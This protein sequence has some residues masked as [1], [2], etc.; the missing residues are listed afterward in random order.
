MGGILFCIDYLL[1]TTNKKDFF[2]MAYN[3]LKGRVKLSDSDSASIEGMVN[4]KDEQTIEG[5]KTFSSIVVA[6]SG[7]SAS[8]FEG[9]GS[10]LTNLDVAVTSYEADKV[11]SILVCSGDSSVSGAVGLSYGEEGL[12][13]Q[14]TIHGSASGLTNI[15][16][17]QFEGKIQANNLSLGDGLKNNGGILE[18]GIV[19][20][21]A[22]E[23]TD[24]G[25]KINPSKTVLKRSPSNNDCFIISDSDSSNETK[26]LTFQSLTTA[27]VNSITTYPPAGN[28]GEIQIKNGSAF[29]GSSELK[30][31]VNS[32][33]LTTKVVNAQTLSGELQSSQ[34]VGTLN[35]SQINHDSSIEADGDKLSVSV[36]HGLTKTED[37]I[38]VSTSPSSALS[39]DADNGLVVEPQNS[40][41]LPSIDNDDLLLI[42]APNRN[43][44]VS[45]VTVGGVRDY[46]Q[47]NLS[48]PPAGV[49]TQIQ[50]NNNGNFGAT[51]TLTFNSAT[52]TIETVNG[53]FSGMV[54]SSGRKSSITKQSEDYLVNES[55]EYVIMDNPESSTVTLP[56]PSADGLRITIKRLGDGEVE[57][58]GTIDNIMGTRRMLSNGDFV[59]LVSLDGSWVIIG[60]SGSF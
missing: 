35:E 1:R 29:Q 3:V 38:Q 30:F 39:V 54:S 48:F 51:S 49:N 58:A 43:I 16:T 2:V 22:I 37:G 20:Q 57:I 41:Q 21:Q 6:N 24:N 52:N 46:L 60:K 4:V 19:E 47:N 50:L 17:D 59:N 40:P 25:L 11:G 8:Y 32:G 28:N 33:T 15:P 42:S 14:G 18:I 56:A 45:N 12:V 13:V 27:F 7:L 34:I 53:S 31:D 44:K 23:S 26:S 9:D 10:G 5:K 55:D 36:S